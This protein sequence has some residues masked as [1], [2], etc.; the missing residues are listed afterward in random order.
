MI[1]IVGLGN[2]GEKYAKTRHN[3]GFILVDSLAFKY[4][5]EFKYEKKFNAEIAE[6]K[7]GDLGKDQIF[8]VKPHTF[9]NNSGDAVQKIA[10]FY[11]IPT[12]DIWLI[13]DEL[14]LP[15][16]D[17]RIRKNGGPGTHNGLK[18]VIAQLGENL[19]RFRIGIESRGTTA[20]QL[21][22]TAS[23]VLSEFFGQ[24]RETIVQGLDKALKAVETALKE[25]LETAMNKFN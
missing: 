19:P 18:S 3:V 6:I 4:Q 14:D 9:M 16:G 2:P 17:L 1:L 21:Q 5:A 22:D 7:A 24:E 11:K 13:H 8:L 10:A 12:S 20:S 15:L 23:F 25:G